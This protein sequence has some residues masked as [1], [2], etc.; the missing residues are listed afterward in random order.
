MAFLPC[1]IRWTATFY[2]GDYEI[3]AKMSRKTAIQE[4]AALRQLKN[5]P[6]VFHFC[7]FHIVKARVFPVKIYSHFSQICKENFF[8][9]CYCV[10]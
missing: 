2:Q 7:P 8:P 1:K 4:Q 5:V 10:G 3:T 6:N 9:V